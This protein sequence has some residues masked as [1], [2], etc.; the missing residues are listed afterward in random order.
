MIGLEA[1]CPDKPRP[2]IIKA[3]YTSLAIPDLTERVEKERV[4]FLKVT[5]DIIN[6]SLP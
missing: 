1:L 5:G 2:K 6:P 3:I 4:W